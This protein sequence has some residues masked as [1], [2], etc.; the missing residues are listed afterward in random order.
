MSSSYYE[1]VGKVLWDDMQRQALDDDDYGFEDEPGKVNRES[2][3]EIV[4][5]S[6]GVASE[7]HDGECIVMSTCKCV[8]LC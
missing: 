3:V 4:L 7:S 6:S 5:E 2:K 8:K 1:D